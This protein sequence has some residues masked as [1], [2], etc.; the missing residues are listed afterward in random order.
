MEA[1][2][3]TRR[4]GLPALLAR[5]VGRGWVPAGSWGAPRGRGDSPR[6]PPAEEKGENPGRVFACA[7]AAGV[8]PTS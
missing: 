6:A 1:Q 8:S 7:V 4:A 2:A 5:S 3:S